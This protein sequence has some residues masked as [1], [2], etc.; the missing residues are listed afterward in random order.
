MDL[1]QKLTGV[2]SPEVKDQDF[3]AL[4]QGN[5]D[6]VIA[7]VEEKENSSTGNKGLSLRLNVFGEKFNNRVLFD[8]MMVEGNPNALKWSLP[9]LKQ[10]GDLCGSLDTNQWIGK[11]ITVN[12]SP[13]NKD[14]TGSKNIVWG[15]LKCLTEMNAVS[16]PSTSVSAGAFSTDDLPF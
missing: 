13:D 5:Y 3:K 14:E 15:Y 8:Y 9:K 1:T 11:T 2:Q 6:V 7:K 12:I 4:P 10:V 16:A